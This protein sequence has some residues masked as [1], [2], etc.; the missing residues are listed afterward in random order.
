L[1]SVSNSYLRSAAILLDRDKVE[2]LNNVADA[3]TRK[4]YSYVEDVEGAWTKKIDEVEF[5]FKRPVKVFA[6]PG[7]GEPVEVFVEPGGEKACSL[8]QRCVFAEHSPLKKGSFK[9]RLSDIATP[10][11]AEVPQ[12]KP[13]IVETPQRKKRTGRRKKAVAA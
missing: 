9:I 4:G 2:A 11:M 12:W 3:L 8:C 10:S 7:V 5:G 1:E 6:V 13:T